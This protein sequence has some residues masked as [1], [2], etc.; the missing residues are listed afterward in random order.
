MSGSVSGELF[1][2]LGAFLVII[3]IGALLRQRSLLQRESAETLNALVINVT[4][5]A[6]VIITVLKADLRPELALLPLL[7]LAVMAIMGGLA[8][9]IGY[10]LRLE[11]PVLG[12]FILAA[13]H[14][15][16]AY[17]GYPLV[18]AVY[19]AA[20]LVEGIFF[21]YGVS[22]VIFT[23]GAAIA[24]HYGNNK[25]GHSLFR[26]L[27][28]FPPLLALPLGLLLRPV[29]LP[30]FMIHSLTLLGDLTVP[31][32]MLSIGVSLRISGMLGSLKISGLAAFM[33]LVAA[34][35]VAV[36]LIYLAG[37]LFPGSDLRGMIDVAAV[38]SGMPT[39]M[40]VIVF[41]LRYGLDEHFLSSAV[42]LSTICG[43]LTLPLLVTILRSLPL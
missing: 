34:P 25:Q 4:L 28:T 18:F 43:L 12:G 2:I 32:V 38:Q 5:P 42:L 22:L 20:G 17:L 27:L 8:W 7:A 31:L 19:G 13:A 10:A 23:A 35:I 37:T 39:G 15:N 33:K 24:R 16:T 36:A 3:A 21:D 40:I 11:K 1:A 29:N 41:A 30:D 14:G 9:L 6:L 26:E